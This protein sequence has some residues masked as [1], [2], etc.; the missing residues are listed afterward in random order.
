MKML[1]RFGRTEL[2][3]R[4]LRLREEHAEAEHAL[5]LECGKGRYARPFGG[6]T[7]AA[8]RRLTEKILVHKGGGARFI[9]IWARG[10]F[11]RN[12]TLESRR[13]A[14]QVDMIE[15]AK[16]WGVE[17]YWPSID[18][19]AKQQLQNG[20]PRRCSTVSDTFATEARGL[21][22]IR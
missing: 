11:Q 6:S 20:D 21:G 19:Y 2:R 16:A 13:P 17:A 1:D 3:A 15:V 22:L 18:H 5:F 7:E 14:N 8:G 12:F 9:E 4:I 10:G